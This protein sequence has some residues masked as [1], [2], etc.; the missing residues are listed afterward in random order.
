MQEVA[1]NRPDP[2]GGIEEKRPTAELS[3]YM[4]NRYN[5]YKMLIYSCTTM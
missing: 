4:K 3:E 1:K 2:T 5:E